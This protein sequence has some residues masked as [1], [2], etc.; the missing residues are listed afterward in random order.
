MIQVDLD[1]RTFLS[2][3]RISI[4]LITIFQEVECLQPKRE[5]KEN[6]FCNTLE[7]GLHGPKDQNEKFSMEKKERVPFCTSLDTNKITTGKYF[8]ELTTII[9]Y[10]MLFR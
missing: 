3:T 4:Q 7:A 5:A 2:S 8:L 1:P 10:L 6:S 9:Y